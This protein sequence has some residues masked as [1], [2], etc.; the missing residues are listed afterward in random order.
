M[1]RLPTC[2]TSL[3]IFKEL[4]D[5][6]LQGVHCERSY[7]LS[8]LF[9]RHLNW[10]PIFQVICFRSSRKP[11]WVLTWAQDQDKQPRSP[12]SKWAWLPGLP[13]P[14]YHYHRDTRS[15]WFVFSWAEVKTNGQR[16]RVFYHITLLPG[17]EW[18]YVTVC[19][20]RPPKFPEIMKSR[21]CWTQPNKTLGCFAQVPHSCWMYLDHRWP[22]K[23]WFTYLTHTEE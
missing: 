11:W 12:A 15:L 5:D 9:P 21:G 22:S 18:V 8:L 3:W 1:T 7:E 16:R 6:R 10:R 19:F 2:R 17:S 23:W 14:Q 13:Q 4:C 20:V